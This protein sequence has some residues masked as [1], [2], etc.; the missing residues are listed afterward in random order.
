MYWWV[1][2]LAGIGA[3]FSVLMVVLMPLF[4]VGGL[5]TIKKERLE[6]EMELEE[7]KRESLPPTSEAETLNKEEIDCNGKE[8][9]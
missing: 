6:F 8:S 3:F 4:I 2:M 7:R 5:M 1:W 9:Y